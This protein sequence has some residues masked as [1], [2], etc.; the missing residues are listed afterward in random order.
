MEGL[1]LVT[2]GAGL[3]LMQLTTHLTIFLKAWAE[4]RLDVDKVVMTVGLVVF[5]IACL[6]Y[7]LLS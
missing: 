4:P 3:V 6:I 5:F 7:V 2:F 1:W